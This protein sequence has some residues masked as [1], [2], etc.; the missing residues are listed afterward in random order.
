MKFPRRESRVEQHGDLIGS[1][2]LDLQ[3]LLTFPQRFRAAF[4]FVDS[5]RVDARGAC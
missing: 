1:R 2:R 4:F 5:T 3:V